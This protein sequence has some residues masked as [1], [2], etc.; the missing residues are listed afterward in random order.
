LK[1]GRETV[2]LAQI[3]RECEAGLSFVEGLSRE[4]FLADPLVQ[5][6]VAMSLV[7]VGE[8]VA[9]L[10][11][12]SPDFAAAHPEI[13]WSAVVGMRNR[14]AHGYYGLDFEAMWETVRQSIPELLAKL[15]N[16]TC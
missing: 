5:H 2:L 1:A 16:P 11:Q 10:L 9:K 12:T 7:V 4:R 14:V 8:T 15:P 13:P 6:A 3:R